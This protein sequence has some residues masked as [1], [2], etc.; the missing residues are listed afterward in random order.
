[1]CGNAYDRPGRVRGPGRHGGEAPALC[2]GTDDVGLEFLVLLFQDKRTEIN[3]RSRTCPCRHDM[4][5][6]AIRTLMQYPRK[7]LMTIRGT[8][9]VIRVKR[10]TNDNSL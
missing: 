10:P 4:A 7:Q 6:G 8:L 9:T 2:V 1:M 5:A 3:G